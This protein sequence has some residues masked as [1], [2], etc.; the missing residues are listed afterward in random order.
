MMDMMIMRLK[1]ACC[2]IFAFVLM[3][4]NIGMFVHAASGYT[5]EANS[6]ELTDESSFAVNENSKTS[7][8][9]YGKSALGS[10]QVSGCVND[11]AT[12]NSMI[13][14]GAYGDVALTYSYRVLC[15]AMIQ[16]IIYNEIRV[17]FSQ[18]KFR[19]YILLPNR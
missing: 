1:R 2:L 18:I 11:Q 7:L 14:I 10:L 17:L 8:L 15:D 5:I 4:S 13:A 3:V 12:F 19:I 16:S 9:C 6:Y